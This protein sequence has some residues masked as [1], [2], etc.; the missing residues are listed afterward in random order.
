[1]KP[2]VF[3]GVGNTGLSKPSASGL[4]APCED[5]TYSTASRGQQRPWRARR[6]SN[7]HAHIHAAHTTHAAGHAAHGRLV[8]GQLAHHALGGQHQAGNRSSILQ[9]GAGHLGRIQDAHFH[10]V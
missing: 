7:L 6:R 1:G 2:R 8:F 10:H 9:R 3:S 4:G 5:S